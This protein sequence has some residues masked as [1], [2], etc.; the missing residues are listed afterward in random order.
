MPESKERI[1]AAL[2]LAEADSAWYGSTDGEPEPGWVVE[3]K[4]HFL[5]LK[6][7]RATL[8]RIRSRAEVDGEIAH[9]IRCWRSNTRG[10]A[11]RPGFT[12]STWEK[13]VALSD[14]PI[15]SGPSSVDTPDPPPVPVSPAGAAYSKYAEQCSYHGCGKRGPFG[16]CSV[17]G[18]PEGLDN[19]SG[20]PGLGKR[21]AP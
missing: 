7:Y 5:A 2:R 20:P 16:T 15:D 3:S 10:M 21:S 13:L 8:H 17:R 14:E 11:N 1:A 12:A 19:P 9:E 18:C 4:A 6:A